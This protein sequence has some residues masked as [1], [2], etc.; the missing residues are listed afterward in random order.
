MVE[1]YHQSKLCSTRRLQ[2]N[3][4]LGRRPSLTLLL[5]LPSEKHNQPQI[6]LQFLEHV[7]LSPPFGTTWPSEL[8]LLS[9]SSAFPLTKVC[10]TSSTIFHDLTFHQFAHNPPLPKTGGRPNSFTPS[11]FSPREP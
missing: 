10:D 7:E 3:S 5:S 8:C 6:C 1:C 9:C 2:S 4:Q 11:A